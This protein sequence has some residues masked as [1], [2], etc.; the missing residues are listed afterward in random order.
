MPSSYHYH[1]LIF[2]LLLIH[3]SSTT[4]SSSAASYRPKS[5]ALPVSRDPST[6][7]LTAKVLQRTPPVII[8]LTLDLGTPFLWVSCGKRYLS[9]TYRPVSCGSPQCTLANAKIC[10]TNNICSTSS[11]KNPVTN[12]SPPSGGELATD[13]IRINSINGSNMGKT[14][15]IP[16][17]LFVCAPMSLLQGLAKGVSGVAG[18]GRTNVSLPSQLAST[19][20]FSRKFALCLSSFPSEDGAL[21]FG[22]G[23]YNF[24]SD[25][26][27]EVTLPSYTPL[28]RNPVRPSE[29]YIGVS[30]LRISQ[31]DVPINKS[32][33]SIDS[34]GNGGTMLSVIYPYTIMETSIY[35]A[36]ITE[37]DNILKTNYK[38][39]RVA[40]IAPFEA[41]YDPSTLP[42]TR[43]GPSVPDINLVLPNGVVWRM[44]AT[45]SLVYS[46]LSPNQSAYCLGFVN[47]GSNPRAS[48]VIGAY[49][50]EDVLVQFDLAKSRLGFTTSLVPDRIRC[51]RFKFNSVV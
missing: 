32:L 42:Y 4:T 18:L 29:Y 1:I 34:K 33:L 28:V 26:D 38:S 41:C 13:V 9:S 21:I 49:Q 43:I 39:K 16:N 8:P 27:V 22:D 44:Q 51:S 10:K 50:L 14:V 37:F 30:A 19:F 40:P 46:T 47:G 31:A 25:I 12:I 24:A 20:S 11:L 45:N 5:I 15:T 23:P 2:S 35:K 48:I 17:Y 7:Q 6:L 36:L 3:Y